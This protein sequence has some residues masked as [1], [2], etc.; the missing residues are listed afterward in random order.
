MIFC[1]VQH[2]DCLLSPAGSISVQLHGQLGQVQL[3]DLRV[4]VGLDQGDVDISFGVDCSDE[5]NVW[6]HRLLL[7]CRRLVFLNPLLPD[8]AS[9]GDPGFIWVDY[10]VA[11]VEQLKELD[12][13][14]LP[15]YQRPV[16]VVDS[17]DLLRPGVSHTQ[18][19][20]HDS[21]HVFE[22]HLLHVVLPQVLSDSGRQTNV[23]GYVGLVLP[24]QVYHP[25]D[26]GLLGSLPLLQLVEETGVLPRLLHQRLDQVGADPV[27]PGYI[28]VELALHQDIM[29]DVDPILD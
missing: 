27:A 16:G 17:F 1:G 20:G 14:L 29:D 6:S 26:L 5:S 24:H 10:P 28:V 7:Q 9:V 19:L 12:R 4:R 13:E 8:V 15:K 11:L 22:R 2:Q 3:E 18:L 21:P 23:A 25:L